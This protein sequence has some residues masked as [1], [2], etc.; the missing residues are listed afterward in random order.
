MKAFIKR[1]YTKK[2]SQ[3]CT[4]TQIKKNNKLEH[5]SLKATFELR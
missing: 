5:V 4:I 3:R 1:P 2:V